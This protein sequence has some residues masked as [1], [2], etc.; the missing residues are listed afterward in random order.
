MGAKVICFNDYEGSFL[1]N[2]YPSPISI[3]GSTRTITFPCAEA[4]YQV[5]K[6]GTK[7]DVD[8]VAACADGP[9]AYRV[10]AMIEPRAGWTAERD[11]NWLQRVVDEK[12]RQ[13]PE[14]ADA[15]V[16]TGDSTLIY[17]G[18]KGDPLASCL[19][20]TRAAIMAERE[21]RVAKNV[22]I[23]AESEFDLKGFLRDFLKPDNEFV[24]AVSGDLMADDVESMAEHLEVFKGRIDARREQLQVASDKVTN[25]FR[26]QLEQ[27]ERFSYAN[28]E[29]VG[30]AIK[31]M[32]NP[33]DK[34]V[35]RQDMASRYMPFMRYTLAVVGNTINEHLD[36]M[37]AQ[38]TVESHTVASRSI[39]DF[40][41]SRTSAHDVADVH[42][43]DMPSGRSSGFNLDL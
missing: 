16:A 13:N 36:K 43:V 20:N 19:T 15:L 35:T 39:E 40:V 26:G 6:C 22:S 32:D 11:R 8:R 14:L 29:T 31:S 41:R 21:A 37:E 34:F 23:D 5:G 2:F 12:F 42:E 10:G 9:E 3:T 30:T 33:L 4:A 25:V 7:E 27:M 28:A 18:P 24:D 17:D 1:S 38:R